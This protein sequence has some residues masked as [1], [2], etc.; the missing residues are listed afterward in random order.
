MYTLLHYNI[1]N[2]IAYFNLPVFVS[3]ILL[4]C[5]ISY[6]YYMLY[7]ILQYKRKSTDGL[8]VLMFILAVFGNLTYGLSILVRQ[9][10]ASYV[11]KHLPWLIGSL[12]VIFLD[13]SVSFTL[14]IVHKFI[15]AFITQLT[16]FSMQYS[17][18]EYL[19]ITLD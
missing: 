11:L 10:D 7:F 1:T 14:Y 18:Y 8:S 17:H 12:G 5:G 16:L 4:Y 6:Q 3:N 15:S 19:Y 9:L 2:S 13:L